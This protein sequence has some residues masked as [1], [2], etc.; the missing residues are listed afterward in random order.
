MTWG[1]KKERTLVV[2]V[3]DGNTLQDILLLPQTRISD[4]YNRGR[5]R[6]EETH[7]EDGDRL[8][9]QGDTG[10]DSAGPEEDGGLVVLETSASGE[11]G[12]E[13]NERLLCKVV[14]VLTPG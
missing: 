7:L 14:R 8:C 6:G 9:E 10:A 3:D 12:S 11:E 2:C 13:G 1:E 5:E 4:W